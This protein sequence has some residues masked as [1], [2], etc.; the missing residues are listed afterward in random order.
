M[1]PLSRPPAVSPPSELKAYQ[2]PAIPSWTAG[3]QDQLLATRM[4]ERSLGFLRLS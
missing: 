4:G 1:E 2:G 3:R